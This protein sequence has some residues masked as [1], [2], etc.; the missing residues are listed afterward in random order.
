MDL[1]DLFHD[2]P[3]ELG[4]LSLSISGSKSL[5]G[6]STVRTPALAL[7]TTLQQ[8][9]SA[10]V[11]VKVGATSRVAAAMRAPR[12]TT[13]TMPK[14]TLVKPRV[15]QRVIRS[16]APRLV[17]AAATSTKVRKLRPY[18]R[19]APSPK[20]LMPLSQSC[21]AAYRHLTCH[22]GLGGESALQL[23]RQIR[24]LVRLQDTRALA[25]SE[26]RDINNTLAFRRSVLKSLRQRMRDCR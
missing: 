11:P 2:A 15:A 25:T 6:G 16:S 10:A 12:P 18:M 5:T 14:F 1:N 17:K 3:E 8:A 13:L 4:T 19:T 9:K 26:H 22:A 24:D 20:Q 7:R 23:L 21:P